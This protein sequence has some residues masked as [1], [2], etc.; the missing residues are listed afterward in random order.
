[1]VTKTKQHFLA[2]DGLRGVAALAVVVF[3]FMEM[4]IYNYNVLWI[5]HGWLA[6]DFFFCLS[7]FVI[8][9][10]YD[11]RIRQMGLK[12]FLEV[13]LIRL[14][15]MVVFGSVLGLLTLLWDPNRTSALAYSAGKVATM[16]VTSVLLIP[17]PVMHERGYSLFSL[18]S[19]AWSLFWEYVAN[20]VYGIVLFRLRRSWLIVATVAAAIVLCGVGHNAGNLWA[21][22]NGKTFWT[23]GA[24]VSFSFLAGLLVYRSRWIVRSRLGFGSL[25]VLLVLAFVMPYATGGW[26]REAAVILV[27]FPLLVALGAGATLGPRAEKLC[28]FA[29]NISYPLYMTHYAV[30]WSFGDFYSSH[31]PDAA[32]L[33]AIVVAGTL[34]LT[35]FAYL[36]M[37]LYDKPVRAYLRSKFV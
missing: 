20:V 2:L 13:R 24:R 32:H 31:K 10:A 36:V 22:F 15:P 18:N 5:G 4:A 9:Y 1:M 34:L 19:P 30:I 29:G 8:G 33:A 14:H 3:H 7:G 12:K 28:K 17:Y 11:D 16:F 37:V 25:S 21:G 35:A 6:V 26:L 27:Y 23:G